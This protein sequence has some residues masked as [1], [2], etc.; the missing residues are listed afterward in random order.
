MTRAAA[1]ISES[2]TVFTVNI[3]VPKRADSSAPSSPPP[4]WNFRCVRSEDSRRAVEALCYPSGRGKSSFVVTGFDRE[5]TMTIML[6]LGPT[7][8]GSCSSACMTWKAIIHRSVF[9]VTAQPTNDV[10]LT[11]EDSAIHA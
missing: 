6:L 2:P 1:K 3:T 9:G 10:A 8:V 4:V 7:D 11:Q 5:V